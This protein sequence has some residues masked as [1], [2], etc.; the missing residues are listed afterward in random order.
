MA[1]V[2]IDEDGDLFGG[3]PSVIVNPVNVVGVMGK[4]LA[5]EFRRRFPDNYRYYEAACA[6]KEL[7][8]GGILVYGRNQEPPYYI[9]NLATKAHWRDPSRIRYVERGMA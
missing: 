3:K 9:V 8:P 4:G 6:R 5:L 2:L 1:R 7:E